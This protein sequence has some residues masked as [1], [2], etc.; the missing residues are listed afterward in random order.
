MLP[1]LGACC[2]EMIEALSYDEGGTVRVDEAGGLFLVAAAV[3]SDEGPAFIDM[4][5]RY[6]PFCGAAVAP[7]KRV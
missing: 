4:D 5:I 1:G 7:Q 6:C 3:D 2:D